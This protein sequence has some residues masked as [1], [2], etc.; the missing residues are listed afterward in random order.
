MASKIVK[1]SDVSVIVSLTDKNT[2]AP[3]SLVGFEGATGFFLKDDDTTLAVTGSL[4][5]ADLGK[6]QFDISP[7]NSS[8]LQAAEDADI[9]VEIK[10]SGK[11]IIAQILDKIEV[12]SRLFS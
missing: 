3:L 4:I 8:L 6:V 10:R 9:E 2:K 5:S 12:S 7:S 1:G 11:V